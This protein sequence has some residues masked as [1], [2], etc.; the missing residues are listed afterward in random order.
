[1]AS[2]LYH[3]IEADTFNSNPTVELFLDT[4]LLYV[5]RPRVRNY[6]TYTRAFHC[7]HDYSFL[8]DYVEPTSLV[9]LHTFTTPF[10]DIDNLE[11]VL[12]ILDR[13]QDHL[14]VL[15]LR[16]DSDDLTEKLIRTLVQG[17]LEKG[18][19]QHQQQGPFRLTKLSLEALSVP[20][21]AI[22]L[23]FTSL[24]LLE[25]LRI[26]EY[27]WHCYQADF[28]KSL[29]YPPRARSHFSPSFSQILKEEEDADI[30]VLPINSRLRVLEFA[31]ETFFHRTLLSILAASPSLVALELRDH[32]KDDTMP[33]DTIHTLAKTLRASCPQLQN[34]TLNS[35]WVLAHEFRYLLCLQESHG[36]STPL[37]S[38]SSSPWLY[39][40]SLCLTCSRGRINYD[41]VLETVVKGGRWSALKET[42]VHLEIVDEEADRFPSRLAG[43][44][45]AAEILQG[46]R[47]LESL[48][49]PGK[50]VLVEHL[51]CSRHLGINRPEIRDEI[52]TTTAAA[53]EDDHDDAT[54]GCGENGATEQDPY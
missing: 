8:F 44:V 16:W 41:L 10:I 53:N 26:K 1:M 40:R 46:F 11:A 50:S 36:T 45:F 21:D 5:L 33:S 17:R 13:N 22:E 23:L 35:Q 51:I 37:L 42:L 12:Q 28:A 18:L 32:S 54:S 27:G 29:A 48:I 34:L 30:L 43:S 52:T 14:Q 49:L 3:T 25:E 7:P 2:R 9:R 15:D 4:S 20:E 38:R 31:T 6:L 39:L 47:G 19:Q 24:S